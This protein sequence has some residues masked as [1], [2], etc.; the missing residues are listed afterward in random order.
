MATPMLP[1]AAPTSRDR[2]VLIVGTLRVTCLLTSEETD[3]AYSLFE[4]V[5]P[6]HD[7]GP[8]PHTHTREDEAFYVLEGEHVV[9]VG[10][11][12]VRGGPGTWMFAPRS[13]PHGFRNDGDVPSRVLMIASP[14]GFE[15]FFEACGVPAM[16]SDEPLAPPSEEQIRRILEEMPRFGMTPHL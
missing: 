16:S 4:V 5:T 11:R 14:G 1:V 2:A 13:V 15:K 7:Q 6:P 10:G 8:P 9:V 3:G 12:E